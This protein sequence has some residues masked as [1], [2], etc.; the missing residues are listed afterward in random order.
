MF[1][2]KYAILHYIEGGWEDDLIEISNKTAKS[3]KLY[4]RYNKILKEMKR[5]VRPNKEEISKRIILE[6]EI[7]DLYNYEQVSAAIEFDQSGG[8]FRKGLRISSFKMDGIG[9]M[10]LNDKVER[11]KIIPQIRYLWVTYDWSNSTWRAEG[12]IYETN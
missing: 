8:K 5:D 2:K 12:V 9:L 10:D 3:E 11:N 7:M 1:Q 6:S 4:V